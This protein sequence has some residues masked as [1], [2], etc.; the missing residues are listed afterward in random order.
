MATHARFR[1][2][3]RP[4]RG[5]GLLGSL[6]IA[7]LTLVATPASA[8]IVVFSGDCVVT[9]RALLDPATQ[10]ITLDTPAPGVCTTTHGG[11]DITIEGD[12]GPISGTGGFSC[13]GG[14]GWGGATITVSTST[15]SVTATEAL[16]AIAATPAGIDLSIARHNAF[17]HLV[18]S[19]AFVQTPSLACGPGTTE[20]TWTG[21]LAFESVD[22]SWSIAVVG[23]SCQ[24]TLEVTLVDQTLEI[25]TPISGT[26]STNFGTGSV[27]VSGS[28]GPAPPLPG[29]GC[30]VG[31]GSGTASLSI[32]MPSRS[33]SA[34][35]GLLDVVQ[36][37]TT[38]ELS[39]VSQNSTDE[40]TAVGVAQDTGN[41]LD[42][43]GAGSP[44]TMT[45]TF[46]FQHVVAKI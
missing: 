38:L 27:T 22:R 23:G 4:R 5:A 44:S 17:V 41:S 20:L 35:D 34:P 1:R 14:A 30:G 29:F 36:T 40:V 15:R 28:A 12:A 25:S 43:C 3:I 45:A 46:A 7:A 39:L 16:L 37:G 31:A 11:G 21:T 32:V 9:L 24:V 33:I 13:A 42:T 18:G 8:D 6:V 10:T 19:G 2:L 26:C